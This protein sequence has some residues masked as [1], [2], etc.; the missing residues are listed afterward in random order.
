MKTP[1]GRTQLAT[2]TPWNPA[3]IEAVVG[4]FLLDDEREFLAAIHDKFGLLDQ[5][6]LT[7]KIEDG[8]DD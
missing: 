5:I 4:P 1:S 6:K 7:A 3:A 2:K 8:D